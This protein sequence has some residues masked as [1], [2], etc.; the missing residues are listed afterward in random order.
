M[1]IP[2]SQQLFRYSTRT[3][4]LAST[5]QIGPAGAFKQEPTVLNKFFMPNVYLTE[6]EMAQKT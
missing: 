1:A 4:S 5:R 6:D 2:L 3:G